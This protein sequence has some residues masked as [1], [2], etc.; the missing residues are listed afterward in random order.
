MPRKHSA[1]RAPSSI[2]TDPAGRLRER[3]PQLASRDSPVAARRIASRPA[4]RRPR[5][6]ARPAGGRRTRPS[7]CR[8]SSASARPRSSSPCRRCPAPLPGPPAAAAM[9]VGDLLDVLEQAR[10]RRC[11]RGSAEYTPSMSVS[12]TTRSALTMTPTSAASVSLSPKRISSTAVVSFS[13]TTGTTPMLEQPLERV[14]RVQVLLAVRRVVPRQQHLPD[15]QRRAR[16]NS[17]AYVPMMPRPGR[18]RRPPAASVMSV[19]R[20][21]Q[22]RAPRRPPRWRPTR[23]AR[24]RAL[25]RA[26]PAIWP[27]SDAQV[28]AVELPVRARE[29]GRADLDDDAA[30]PRATRSSSPRPAPRRPG[31]ART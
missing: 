5:R 16:A 28:R 9:S 22:A 20:A 10:A 12:S 4:C 14:A 15:G 11:V 1:S 13:F 30:C 31:R 21:R 3:D 24:P 23:R 7:G 2:V 26:A 27:T 29:R 25:A 8:P 18:P 6:R 17:S 19:G